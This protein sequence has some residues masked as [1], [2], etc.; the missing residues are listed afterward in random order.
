MTTPATAP[1]F[2]DLVAKSQLVE[3]EHF[4]GEL[5]ALRATGPLPEDAKELAHLLVH[6]GLL[7][8][9]QAD[10]LLKGRWRGFMLG[11]YK[12]LERLGAGGMGIVYLAEHRYLLRRVALKVLPVSLAEDRWF[13]EHFYKEAQAVASLHHPNIVCAHDIDRDGKLHFLVMEYI[14]GSNLE[15]IVHK[16]GV[17]D[18]ARVAHYIRQA[19][20]GLQCAHGKGLVHRDIKPGNLVLDRQGVIKILD[21]GLACFT[22]KRQEEAAKKNGK[23]LIVGTDD[24]L[25][26]EQIVD[27]DDVD[28]R[29][30]IYSLGATAYYL[31]AG[32]PPF[33]DVSLDHHKLIWHLTRSPKP[34][35]EWRP[36]LPEG[37]VSVVQKMM[38]KNPWERY[39]TPAAVADALAPWTQ[40]P[41]SP[42]PA[43]EMPG[44][45]LA[46]RRSGVLGATPPSSRRGRSSWIVCNSAGQASSTILP[47]AQQ[48]TPSP[49]T[50][51]DTVKQPAPATPERPATL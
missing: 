12:I 7:T 21:L 16:H 22:R 43:A 37:L 46:A 3:P 29:A 26:P 51:A 32:K 44:L 36:E 42:P 5:E 30:D 17:M 49:S 4:S 1:D 14:E 48:P 28:G 10:Q 15:E 38:A 13:L 50:P 25:A 2:L 19:A 18:P 6:H 31:L 34:L 20:L 47:G 9:F 35:S 27:S 24:Y 23:R 11:K 45:C 41:I 40:T 8:Y 33:H 39:Q